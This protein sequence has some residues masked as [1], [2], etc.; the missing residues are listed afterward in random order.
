MR[1]KNEKSKNYYF[2]LFHDKNEY[3]LCSFATQEVSDYWWNRFIPLLQKD[4]TV[5]NKSIPVWLGKN[6]MFEMARQIIS[7]KN[8]SA[9]MIQNDFAEKIIKESQILKK[10]ILLPK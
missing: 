2:I 10:E 9:Q 6:Q 3:I 1:D 4:A 5:H 8:L 7:R